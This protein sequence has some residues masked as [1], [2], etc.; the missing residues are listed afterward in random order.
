MLVWNKKKLRCDR[1][2]LLL[3]L[4]KEKPGKTIVIR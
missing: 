3:L 1:T 4:I 2:K